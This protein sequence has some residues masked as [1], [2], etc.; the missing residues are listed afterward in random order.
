MPM[1]RFEPDSFI[2]YDSLA[3][4]LKARVETLTRIAFSLSHPAA[5]ETI[6]CPLRLSLGVL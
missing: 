2:D 6:H 4:K 1:S 3:D 5:L